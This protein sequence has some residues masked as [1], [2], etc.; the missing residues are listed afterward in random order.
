M[1]FCVEDD[2][3]I[4]ELVVYTLNT[5]EMTKY[6]GKDLILPAEVPTRDM[7]EF[8]AWNTA[9]DGTGT[10]YLPGSVYSNDQAVT[11]YAYWKEVHTLSLPESLS[12]IEEEAF[13]G[14]TAQFIFVPSS[15]VEIHSRAFA[16]CS[17]LQR[18]YLSGA[19]ESIAL[20]AFE[21]CTKVTV[22]APAGSTAIKVAKYND[23][24]YVETETP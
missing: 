1:I 11:L 2:S 13:S 6:S 22:Y 7:Y 23:I 8:V 18:I 21:G 20:D 9:P 12:I 17:N 4:R 5:T 19:T 3:N 14:I 10:A 24:P 15:C 16:N